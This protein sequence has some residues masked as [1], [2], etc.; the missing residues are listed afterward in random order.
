MLP[1][2]NIYGEVK[3]MYGSTKLHSW[4]WGISTMCPEEKVVAAIKYLDFWMSEE[5][6]ELMSFGPEGVSHTKG[7]NG[8]IIWSEEALAFDS[9]VPNYMRSIGGCEIGTVQSAEATLSGMN[10]SGARG[11][12]MYEDIIYPPHEQLA[13]TEEEQEILN[14]CETNIQTAVQ[15][16]MQRWLFGKEDPDKTWDKY[17]KNLKSIGFDK[18]AK[19]YD[20]AFRRMY[21]KAK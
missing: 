3:S 21:G 7:A 17:I 13:F 20:D 1:P 11:Y 19:V 15:E 12:K 2:E 9:G 5:G 4:A 8:E 18:F 14:E 16:Q 10:E 6:R